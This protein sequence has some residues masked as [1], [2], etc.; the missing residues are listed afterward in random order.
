MGLRYLA[1]GTL[2]VVTGITAA[3]DVAPVRRSPVQFSTAGSAKLHAYGSRTAQQVASATGRKMDAALA[4]ISR[5]LSQVRPEHAI[6]DLHK[7]NPAARFIQSADTQPM[8]LIDAV[9]RAEPAA[10]K[11]ALVDLGLQHPAVFSN[12]V[13]GWLPVAQLNAATLRDEVH[14]IR[15]AMPRTRTGAVTTQGDYVQ[16]SDAVRAANSLDGSGV[17]VGILSDSYDCYAVYAA[18]GVSA[19]GPTGYA[20]NTFTATAATDIS[21]GDLPATV[22]VLE[23]AE[24]GNGG[25]MNY[26]PKYQLPFGDEGRAMM[27]VIHD[28]APGAAL[29]FYTA[30]NSEAD[31]ASGIEALAL[32]VAQGGAVGA[33]VIADDV[34]YPDEPFFQDGIVAQ[35]IDAVEASGVAYFSAAGNNGTLGYDNLHPTFATAG[36]GVNA[37]EHLL[38]FDTSGATTTTTLPVTIPAMVPGEF[39]SIVLEWDQPYVTGAKNSGGATSQLDL[40]VK[41][42]GGDDLVTDDDLNVLS[43]GCTGANALGAD[44]VQVLV[45]AN[46]A[47]SGVNSQIETLNIVIGLK[48]GLA[49]GRIKLAV[50]DDGLGSTIN[51]FATNSGTLQGHPGAAGAMAVGAAFFFD[52]PAC[53][54]TPAQLE[55]FSSEGG[56][57]ILFDV[58]LTNQTAPRLTTPVTRQKPDVVGPDGGNNTFLGFTLASQPGA[59]GGQLNTTIASCQ[60]NTSYPNFFG[61]SA[62]TPHVAAIAA[63]FLQAN[64]SLTPTEIYTAL[65]EG[66]LAMNTISPNYQ[67]GYGFVQANTSATMIPATLPAAPTLML[68]SASITLGASTTL[69]WSSA[70][71]TGCTASGSWSG[72]LA[73]SGSQTL[74]PTALGTD[75]YTL[76]CANVAGSSPSTSVSL[77]V[78]A[79]P[80]HHGGGSLGISALLGLAGLVAISR[81]RR[82]SSNR[83]VH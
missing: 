12:D 35:A 14:A 43:T 36:N 74:T 55:P 18:N 28:V 32:P 5:S 41:V 31:F 10:L 65:R 20:N 54:T 29:A 1:L 27:Q 37:G 71:T 2:A 73:S 70:N 76:V 42:T 53:G 48:S 13:G 61:T 15:A 40:C 82:C 72:A 4:E 23:E 78:A 49:P 64:A 47:D 38:N 50:D 75:T 79:A 7:M 57:P 77:T 3:S 81:V 26:D 30:V 34:G 19:S 67:S 59:M 16:H 80:S 60:N 52:T 45:L 6:Q 62:A 83:R 46:P 33:K 63:L 24:A 44:P 25:C 51:Q 58:D 8:V 39:V 21:T 69:T 9:T 56:T 68:S 17:T 11:A 22:H 66:A